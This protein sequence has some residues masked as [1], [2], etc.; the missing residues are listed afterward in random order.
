MNQ[1]KNNRVPAIEL[2]EEMLFVAAPLLAERA[3][4]PPQPINTPVIS[5]PENSEVRAKNR[6]NRACLGNHNR[7]R[8]RRQHLRNQRRAT[9]RH[10]KDETCRLQARFNLVSLAESFDWRSMAKEQIERLVHQRLNG[11]IKKR[12][13]QGAR[14]DIA[15]FN[16][17]ARL[18]PFDLNRNPTIQLSCFRS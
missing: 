7:A 13:G 3:D 14:S 8:E 18:L 6:V 9:A 5:E 1:R 10:M 15:P 16:K 2:D 4:H 11:L 12:F 17:G